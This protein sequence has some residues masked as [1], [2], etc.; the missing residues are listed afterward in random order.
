M[1]PLKKIKI[2]ELKC[3]TLTEK[4]DIKTTTIEI[5]HKDNIVITYS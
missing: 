3:G 2:K 1:P 5:W 4:M